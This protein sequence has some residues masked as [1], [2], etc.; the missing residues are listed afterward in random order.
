M[1]E[2]YY[3]ILGIDKN[4]SKEEIKKAY[5]K[6]AKQHHPDLN[7]EN[8]KE[9]EAQFK[10]VNEAFSILG[11]E[12]KKQQY[13]SLG[14]DAFNQSSRTGGYSNQGYDF[15]GGFGGFDFEDLFEG[16]FGGSSS[17]R[18]SRRKS[19]GSDLRYDMTISL[20]EAAF[21]TEREITI[22]KKDTCKH[23]KGK[24]GAEEETCTTCHGTGSIRQIKRTP[25]GAFQ[26]TSICPD[27]Q[28]EGKKIKNPC[29][30]C[31]GT[32]VTINEKTIKVTIPEGVEEGTRLKLSSEGEAAPR[33][34]V[35]GDLYVFINVKKHPVFERHGN[36]I[37]LETPI[38]FSQAV[39][40]ATIHIPTLDG[41]AKLKIPP[42]T[43]SG[44]T[45]KMSG[46][47]IP[48]LHS[49]GRGNQL[50]QVMVYTPQ[51]LSKKQEKV[52]KEY[53]KQMGDSELPK[54]SLF[55]KLKDYLKK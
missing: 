48:Y 55:D 5:K 46:K 29:S 16:F 9:A 54:K 12:Q 36:D 27:C 24:G 25:F 33:N 20:E 1:S 23:C 35:T 17:R 28:G 38:S 8:K 14:H 43:Q 3:K 13:D 32:G 4:A 39:F 44:T 49:R 45:F 15:S 47:G 11:D 51:S 41:K 19:R 7:K 26:S 50:V 22:R 18:S 34:G 40:G 31:D 2:D 10:K 30:Y 52:L 6:K 53:S 42:G 21:G 37:Y